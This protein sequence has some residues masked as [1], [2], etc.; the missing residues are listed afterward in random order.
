[1]DPLDS[2]PLPH[3]VYVRVERQVLVRLPVSGG[4]LFTIRT[5]VSDIR[6]VP[7]DHR[8][9]LLASL[10]P[11]ANSTPLSKHQKAV[12]GPLIRGIYSAVD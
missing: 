8:P 3:A 12:Y 1:M 7:L 6:N 2:D 4:V 5:Y 11:E 10:A 9:A